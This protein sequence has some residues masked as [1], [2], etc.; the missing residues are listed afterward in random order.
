MNTE[1]VTKVPLSERRFSRRQSFIVI[2]LGVVAII[3]A[4]DET[5]KA[6]DAWNDRE[7]AQAKSEA[8]SLNAAYKELFSDPNFKP[9]RHPDFRPMAQI[10]SRQEPTPEQAQLSSSA[11]ESTQRLN[12]HLPRLL[13]YGVVACIA[14]VV[15][16]RRR[17]PEKA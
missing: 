5:L 11:E 6:A 14:G 17:T 10:L 3:K 2:P 9:A 12:H 16:L 8:I 13:A 15:N 1:V 4:A 7:N